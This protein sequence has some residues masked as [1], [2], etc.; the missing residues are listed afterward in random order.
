MFSNN[1]SSDVRKNTITNAELQVKMMYAFFNKIQIPV[2]ELCELDTLIPKMNPGDKI[3]KYA[4]A[5]NTCGTILSNM[6]TGLKLYYDLKMEIYESTYDNVIIPTE[7]QNIWE[8]FV[9]SYNINDICNESSEIK[10]ELYL[11]EGTPHD[12]AHIDL[13]LF[14]FII[15]ELIH[16]A[17]IY[18]HEGNIKMTVKSS[19]TEKDKE[20]IMDI[21]IEDTGEGIPE[22][23][24]HDV[25]E[26]F[27]KC[28]QNS[29][30]PG[31]GLP[32][33]RAACKLM[34]G[35]LVILKSRNGTKFRAT[36]KYKTYTSTPK[37]S[38]IDTKI[39]NAKYKK[40]SDYNF[41]KKLLE[42]HEREQRTSSAVSEDN[43]KQVLIVEDS[44][45]TQMLIGSFLRGDKFRVISSRS[46]KESI[47]LCKDTKYDVILMDINMPE[48]NGFTAIN[49]IKEFCHLNF[50]TP[51]VVM[52]GTNIDDV[53]FLHHTDSVI[54]FLTNPITK[55]ILIRVLSKYTDP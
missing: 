24:I 11:C 2:S 42:Q 14:R 8:K 34:N 49:R 22:L 9:N 27:M 17:Y 18:T 33:A 44:R 10:C 32:T 48:M 20:Y 26:P 41:Q 7:I 3:F 51:I 6:I 16:N 29:L 35:D 38:I 31:L 15:N 1:V 45:I 47:E 28:S 46:G 5:F 50:R 43:R 12:I 37:L 4:Q 39:V 53:G 40:D 13:K 25:F 36:F 52:S 30:G 55:D 54:H 23:H 21:T 19:K